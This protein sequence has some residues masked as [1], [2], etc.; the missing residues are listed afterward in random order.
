[1]SDSVRTCQDSGG[2]NGSAPTCGK[3]PHAVNAIII[4]LTVKLR[5][6]QS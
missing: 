3:S 1:M 2:W 6:S 4:S 5:Y